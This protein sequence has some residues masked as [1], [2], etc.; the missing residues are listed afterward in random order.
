MGL[1]TPRRGLRSLAVI[2]VVLAGP[3]FFLQHLSTLDLDTQTG[4]RYLPL[5]RQWD[6]V[7][8]ETAADDGAAPKTVGRWPDRRHED[9]FVIQANEYQTALDASGNRRHRKIQP[10]MPEGSHN[11][12]PNGLVTVNPTGRHPI[13]DLVE[14]AQ[15]VW[16]EKNSKASKTLSE[17]INEYRRRYHRAPPKGFDRW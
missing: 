15:S 9:G 17:A 8:G 10:K 4:S 11:Y 14:R 1:P 5:K 13:Y 3:Y 2:L 7:F 16:K 6:G 12:L